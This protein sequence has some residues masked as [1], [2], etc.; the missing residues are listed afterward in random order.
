ML[1][2]FEKL[3]Y[4]H[5]PNVFSHNSSRSYE[6]IDFSFIAFIRFDCL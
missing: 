5:K 6:K 2:S 3:V 1:A 4:K